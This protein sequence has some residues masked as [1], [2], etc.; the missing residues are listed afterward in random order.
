MPS[1]DLLTGAA[2]EKGAFPTR[3][4]MHSIPERL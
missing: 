4:K 2:E 3:R 1:S